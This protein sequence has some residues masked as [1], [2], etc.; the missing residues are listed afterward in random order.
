[1]KNLNIKDL[2][3][4][5]EAHIELGSGL[6][7]FTG[8][9]GAGKTALLTAIDLL[10]GGRADSE[11]IRQGQQ[12]AV[13][14]AELSDFSS[15][16]LKD[17][18]IAPNLK[19]VTIRRE[20]HASG[21]SRCFIEDSLVSVGFLRTFM[22]SVIE[23][24]DQNSAY[25]LQQT[26]EQRKIL[27]L[28][29][30]LEKESAILEGLYL[31]HK[32]TKEL[33]DETLLKK[34][35]KEKEL[36]NFKEAVSFIEEVNLKEGEEEDLSYLHTTFSH[37]QKRLELVS[38]VAD[39][40]TGALVC[41]GPL[42]SPL[43]QVATLDPTLQPLETTLKTTLLEIKELER[44]V[45][46][47]LENIEIDPNK[48]TSIEERL[49]QIEKLRRRFGVSFEEIQKQKIFFLNEIE[50]LSSLDSYLSEL[51][52]KEQDLSKEVLFLAENLFEKRK[53]V[54]H[55]FS[56]RILEE[57]KSLNLPK[58]EFQVQITRKP[59]SST[60]IDAISF[61][62]SANPG[63]PLLPLDQCASGGEISRLLFAAKTILAEEDSIRC[64]IFDE[65][66]SNVGGQ[67][68]SI[69]GEKLKKMAQ[70]SQILC[71]THFVQV[72][73]HAAHH[74]SVSKEERNGQAITLVK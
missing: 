23:M 8:E 70:K 60:G 30:K 26:E 57:L 69:L 12:M 20:I 38:S 18:E 34:E 55:F 9:T 51:Q 5:D 50:K 1:M 68:A 7:I 63:T 10:M 25:L 46:S 35:A 47:Y 29:G 54:A 36:E 74:F 3:L 62:F 6:N 21:K 37:A 40:L 43:T 39:G 31:A 52:K 44:T 28:F 15:V 64:L 17:L 32:K 11:W 56:A 61:I 45:H 13:V 53:K 71:V 4:V 22:Q 33:L 72:A 73:K 66:D 49:A 2:I 48:L 42:L 67:T 27:D 65:I 41:L 58:A 19:T 24:V 16:L 14:E 59:L